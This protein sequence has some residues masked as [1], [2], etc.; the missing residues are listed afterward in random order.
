[1]KK[2]GNS[3]RRRR[4]C[5]HCGQDK[6]VTGDHVIP[7]CL[8]AEPSNDR[9][10]KVPSCEECNCK[11]EEGLLKS[12]FS[13]F[14]E[15]IAE[16]RLGDELLRPHNRGDL[17][18]FAGICSPGL[19]LAF[20]D[21]R[22]NRLLKKMFQGLRRELLGD[23]WT[24]VPTE[25]MTLF[26][27]SKEGDSHVVRALPVQVGGPN[28]GFLMPDGF[29]Q[30]DDH[31]E[32]RFRDFL[33]DMDEPDVLWLKYAR[34]FCGNQLLLAGLF[35]H[36]ASRPVVEEPEEAEDVHEGGSKAAP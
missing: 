35:Q 25:Q 1:M 34:T 30:E 9:S 32:H 21:A 7:T 22:V 10:I 27:L 3:E 29:P 16:V 17:R 8:F 5:T 23:A 31:F 13:L 4:I 18:S 6:R 14:D 12:F 33:F 28:P 2:P 15:R 11:S 24:F 20:P 26:S 19:G 36:P